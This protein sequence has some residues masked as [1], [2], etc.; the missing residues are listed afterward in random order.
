M[1]KQKMNAKDNRKKYDRHKC[2]FYKHGHSYEKI[3]RVWYG[4]I[5]RCYSEL[6]KSYH[7]YG[8][9]GITVCDEWKNDFQAFYDWAMSNGYKEGLQIDRIDNNGNYDPKNC[10]FVTASE[11]CRNRRTARIIEFNGEKKSLVEW[12]EI[13][14]LNPDTITERIKNGWSVEEALTTIKNGRCEKRERC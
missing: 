14:G 6:H 12:S 2:N 4:I 5:E 9:R 1:K 7:E 10:R 8:G 13:T 3:H 11:N